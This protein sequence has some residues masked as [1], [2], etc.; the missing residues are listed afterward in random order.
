MADTK[1]MESFKKFW[2][3]C[4]ALN[5]VTVWLVVIWVAVLFSGEQLGLGDYLQ[6]HISNKVNFNLRRALRGEAPL[7]PRIKIFALDD[8][9]VALRGDYRI[10]GSALVNLLKAIDTR[11]PAK[12]MIDSMYSLRQEAD[13]NGDELIA[14]IGSLKSTVVVG[15]MVA[16]QPIPFR[17]PIDDAKFSSAWSTVDQLPDHIREAPGSI[18]YGP[19]GEYLRAFDHLG[20]FSQLSERAFAPAILASGAIPVPHFSL[21]AADSKGFENGELVVDGRIVELDEKGLV[22]IDFVSSEMINNHIYSL[23]NFFAGSVDAFASV[24]PGDVVVV[25]TEYTS[26]GTRFVSS[27]FGLVPS[28]YVLIATINTV[29]KGRWLRSLGYES[30]WLV[31]LTGLGFATGISLSAARFMNW[32]LPISVVLFSLFLNLFVGHGIEVPWAFPMLGYLGAALIG[33]GEQRRKAGLRQIFLE[34]ERQTAAVLQRDFLPPMNV[35]HPYFDLAATYMAAETIGGDWFAHGVIGDRW[36]YMH[37]GDVTGHGAASA[38]LASFAKGATDALHEEHSRAHG[39]PAH[40]GLVHECL[41]RIIRT[42]SGRNLYMT[43]QSVIIDLKTGDYSYSNSGH[44]PAIILANGKYS[45][46]SRPINNLLG[47][48]DERQDLNVGRGRLGPHDTLLFF[49]DGLLD[50]TCPTGKKPS[51]RL[52]TK[53][54]QSVDHTDAKS[55][56]RLLELRCSSQLQANRQL[57]FGDD[58]T[59]IVVKMQLAQDCTITESAS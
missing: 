12:I 53:L 44:E 57:N 22:P 35:Q 59:F 34:S 31:V 9:T 7:D 45:I 13:G 38:M 29:L 5:T 23:R 41:N 43:L 24:A 49:S 54:L 39:Q 36:L 2:Q 56:Q 14:A 46:L 27:P 26:G 3:W 47:H 6:T 8:S 52:L 37:L 16:A 40:L 55:L 33:H 21:Y 4:K 28:P 50:A 1:A 51:L 58:V 11:N 15:A 20:H 10:S 32:F 42:S 18:I 48:S 19:E 30:W 17:T 25:L